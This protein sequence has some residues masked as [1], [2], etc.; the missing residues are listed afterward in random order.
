MTTT[1]KKLRHEIKS[2]YNFESM[3]REWKGVQ[4][5]ENIAAKRKN[6]LLQMN[7]ETKYFAKQQTLYQQKIHFKS[8]R[9]SPKN[10]ENKQSKNK[11][12]YFRQ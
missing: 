8:R 10:S 3:R 11:K 6:I 4:P 7:I 12:L 1:V 9:D 5:T 2:K